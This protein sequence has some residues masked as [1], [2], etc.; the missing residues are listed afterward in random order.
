MRL[1]SRRANTVPEDVSTPCTP[2]LCRAPQRAPALQRRSCRGCRGILATLRQG[3]HRSNEGI[4]LGLKETCGKL[5]SLPLTC[6]FNLVLFQA[7]SCCTLSQFNSELSFP[8]KQ[9]HSL[10]GLL[11]QVIM[12]RNQSWTYHWTG[13]RAVA[14]G[15]G[16]TGVGRRLQRGASPL[17]EV[18]GFGL[19]SF[20]MEP[21]VS[22]GHANGQGGAQSVGTTSSGF[23]GDPLVSQFLVKSTRFAFKICHTF[24]P[25][26]P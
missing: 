8:V 14:H 18:C 1:H 24:F 20:K 6:C 3:R 2:N 7:P 23:A 16:A 9:N 17:K 11:S 22:G 26:I 25:S 15:Q 19:S 4:Q 21:G 5:C 10:L 13:G 12:A